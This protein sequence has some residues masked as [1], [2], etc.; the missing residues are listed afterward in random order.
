MQREVTA[1][2]KADAPP[3]QGEGIIQGGTS[4]Q[5]LLERHLQFCLWCAKKLCQANTKK[6]SHIWDITNHKSQICELRL[7]NTVEILW[8]LSFLHILEDIGLGGE[9][10]GG[11]TKGAAKKRFWR[12]TI[13]S[14]NRRLQERFLYVAQG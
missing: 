7:K 2:Q 5:A 4:L 3:E 8:E 11:N 12:D 14:C 10:G 13:F 1:R 9:R 6:R